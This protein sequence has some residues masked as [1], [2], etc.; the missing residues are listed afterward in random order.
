MSKNFELLQR[1]QTLMEG[2]RPPNDEGNASSRLGPA[3][4]T[5]DPFFYDDKPPATILPAADLQPVQKREIVR[6]I[7]AVFL[8]TDITRPRMVAIAGIDQ[9]PSSAWIAAC[10]GE[11]LAA[12]FGERVCVVDTNVSDGKLHRLFGVSNDTGFSDAILGRAPMRR[13]C[14]RMSGKLWILSAGS[15]L[16]E[17]GEL[18][19][20]ST[21]AH[22]DELRRDFFYSLIVTPP[23]ARSPDALGLARMVDSILLVV[24]AD[25]TRRA[26]A[27]AVKEALAAANV[28]VVGAILNNRTFPVPDWLYQRL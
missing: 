7:N 8:P 17:E 20:A 14:R 6:L 3:P 5:T 27:L 26:P 21:K 19:R 23:I 1:T 11:L 9:Y 28:P 22:L 2:A 13:A 18:A 10:A 16:A 12:Q 24:E 4:T 25:A 15:P